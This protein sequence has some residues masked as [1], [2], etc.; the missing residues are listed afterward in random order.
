[1]VHLAAKVG[2]GQSMYEIAR[3]VGVNDLGTAVLLE[4]LIDHPVER[5]V[6]ASSMSVYG[7]GLYQTQ[8]RARF[9]RARRLRNRLQGQPISVY[10]D[11][12][13]LQL[14]LLLGFP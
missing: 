8:D 11:G 10:G 14:P 5:V 6:L 13:A 4:C 9:E 1:M 7:E 3:Y 2:V 12:Q